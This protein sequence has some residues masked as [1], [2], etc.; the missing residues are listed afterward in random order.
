MGRFIFVSFGLLVVFLSLSGTAADCPPD[1]SSYEGSCYRVFEQKMNWED[2]EKFCTQQQTGGHLVSFQSSEEADFVVSLTSP[3][4]R[5]SFVWTGLSDVWKE[6][7][8]EWSDGSDLSYKDNYQFVFSEYEC[9]ASKTKNNKWRIIPCTK[10][11]YFVCE[12][13]A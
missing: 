2:A 12:F 9:V 4:L 6:C 13:Q 8:F 5:D 10:L 11:E 1:W 7:S 3:I